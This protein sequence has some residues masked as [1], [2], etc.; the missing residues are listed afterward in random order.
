MHTR[1]HT[2]SVAAHYND[3]DRFY[4]EIWGEHV[5]HGFW[6]TGQE[7]RQEAVENLI[8]KVAGAGALEPGQTVYDIGAGYGASSRFLAEHFRA[9]V[10]AI[11]VSDA[12]HAYA[13]SLARK[14]GAPRY[15]LGDFLEIPLPALSGDLAIAIESTEH[16]HRPSFFE[17]AYRILRSGGRIVVCAWLSS[18]S[19]RPWET[20]HLLTP[21]RTEGKLDGLNTAEDYL[22]WMDESKFKKPADAV[23]APL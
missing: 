5:H 12:Q 6:Q 9:D 11:T 3:L 14:P 8:R 1:A 7:T 23:V 19:A 20:R 17:K 21:I 15:L 4:R 2:S 22:Q 13:R 10:T 18:P 16:M